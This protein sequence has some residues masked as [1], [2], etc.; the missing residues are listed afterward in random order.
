MALIANM[1]VLSIC[2]G[3]TR[4][5]SAG[6][7]VRMFCAKKGAQLSRGMAP[8]LN[9][10]GLLLTFGTE[11]ARPEIIERFMPLF[12]DGYMLPDTSLSGGLFLTSSTDDLSREE[13]GIL[14]DVLFGA[15]SEKEGIPD[16]IRKA[17]DRF[18]S[19]LADAFHADRT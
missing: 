14:R 9:H 10:A 2:H 16:R 15:P 4:Y 18:R 3:V 7:D 6:W 13:L 17:A 8:E 19:V 1:D 11:D 5:S 12:G